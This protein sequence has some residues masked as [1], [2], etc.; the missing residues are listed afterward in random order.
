MISLIPELKKEHPGLIA[1]EWR[2]KAVHVERRSSELEDF[3]KAFIDKVRRRYTLPQLKDE[4]VFRRYRD[5]F[6]RLGIDP[7]KIRP[8]SEALIRRVLRGKEIPRINTLVDAYNL[9]SMES[10]IALAAFD[11][12]RLEGG[13][14]LRYAEEGESFTGIGMKK[15][16]ILKGGEIVIEDGRKLIAIYPYRDADNTRIT[17]GT[18]NVL[19]VACGVPGI[20]KS[21]LIQAGKLGSDYITRFCGGFSVSEK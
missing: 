15:E 9:A 3:K 17:C 1:L 19:L 16:K 14:L 11:I 5:F 2:I 12:D 10:G 4:E 18:T 8:A 6:W 21:H 13:L 7:T 20:R